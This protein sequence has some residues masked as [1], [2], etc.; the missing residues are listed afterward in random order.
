MTNPRQLRSLTLG[1]SVGAATGALALAIVFLLTFVATQAAQAQTFNVIHTFT[2]GQDGGG[3]HAG[4]TMHGAGNLYGTALLGLGYGTV[5][6][7]KHKGS[8]WVFNP[9]YSFAGGSDGA[10]PYAG[11]VFGP[12]GLLYGTTS[13]ADRNNRYGTVFNL[14][15]SPTACKS[16]LC[17]VDRNRALCLPGRR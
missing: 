10:Y 6:E 5:Y 15:P 16:A 17:P 12:D 4:L 11:V 8:G 9:L 1:L 13:G 3:P 7:L 14:R 2:G